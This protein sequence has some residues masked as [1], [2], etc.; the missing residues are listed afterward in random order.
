MSEILISPP[1]AS[2]AFIAANTT[3][4]CLVGFFS[5]ILSVINRSPL[6]TDMRT[7][8][9]GVPVGLEVSPNTR[10]PNKEMPT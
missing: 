3:S 5:L 8:N 10:S 6:F 1:L 4:A 7:K 2:I 9:V